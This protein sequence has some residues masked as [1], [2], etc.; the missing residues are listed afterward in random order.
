MSLKVG[1][2]GTGMMGLSHIELI[3]DEFPQVELAAVCDPHLPYLEKAVAAAPKARV[4]KDLAEV[5]ATDVDAVVIS[6]PGH[7]HAAPWSSRR[8]PG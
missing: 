5:C 3:R 8:G 1:F 7:T 2:L 4:C 6:T